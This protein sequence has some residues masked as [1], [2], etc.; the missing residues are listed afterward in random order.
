LFVA[1]PP[2]LSKV[3][4]EVSIGPGASTSLSFTLMNPNHIVTLHAL[5]FS[6]TLP[7][8]LVISTP[9]GLAGT[10]GGGTISAVAGSDLITVDS[11][12]L[13]P[14]ASCTFSVNVTSDGTVLGDVDQYDQYGN[15]D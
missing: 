7:A 5:Q 8:G 2:N 1:T 3:F 6:D 13:A 12:V 4:G 9:N 11:A 10:C 14:Q 15:V